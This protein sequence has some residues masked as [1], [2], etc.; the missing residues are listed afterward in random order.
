MPNIQSK[1]LNFDTAEFNKPLQKDNE[2]D[3]AELI[4]IQMS[5]KLVVNLQKLFAQMMMS[6]IKYLDPKAVLD[7]IVDDSG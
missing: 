4:K 7:T 1:L 2:M 3:K 6:N 5:R